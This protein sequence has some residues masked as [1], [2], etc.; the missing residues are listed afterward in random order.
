M[1]LSAQEYE[2]LIKFLEK[3]RTQL[4]ANQVYRDLPL[5]GLRQIRILSVDRFKG[6]GGT[7]SSN[8]ALKVR[9]YWKDREE[10]EKIV[11]F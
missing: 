10:D 9:L 6:K 8:M 1:G 5:E 3:K 4:K 7:L 2:M 11:L